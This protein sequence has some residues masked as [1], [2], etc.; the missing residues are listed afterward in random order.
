M[1]FKSCVY[2]I[3]MM[4]FLLF[5][6]IFTDNVNNVNIERLVNLLYRNYYIAI[7][8]IDKPQPISGQTISSFVKISMV[9]KQHLMGD[10]VTL[11]SKQAAAATGQARS[12]FFMSHLLF[13]Y[14][15]NPLI[16]T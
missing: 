11:R 9:I 13:V 12:L 14:F 6:Y 15:Y 8:C 2:Q 4:Y 3:C 16:T 10:L 7:V 1:A 5:S